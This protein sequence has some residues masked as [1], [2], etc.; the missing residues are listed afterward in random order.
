L[1][2]FLTIRTVVFRITV[3]RITVFRHEGVSS[4]V[5]RADPKA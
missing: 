1:R 5:E 4:E 3:F 2:W